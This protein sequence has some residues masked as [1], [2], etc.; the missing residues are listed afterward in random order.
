MFA[1]SIR[2][3]MQLWQAFLLVCILSGFG[4]TAFQL[5]RTNWLRQVD[6]ELERRVAVLSEDVRGPGPLRPP[7]G[8]SPFGPEPGFDRRHPFESGFDA[9]PPLEPGP[10]FGP[11][12]RPRPEPRGPWIPPDEWPEPKDVQ[13]S[14]KALSLFGSVEPGDY[15]Y[16]IWS[17]SGVLLKR[18]TNA[19]PEL[20]LPERSEGDTRILARM[21]EWHREAW[22]FTE[23]GDCVL[24]GRSIRADLEGM[25]RLAGLLAL[26]G[27][28]VLA[29][30][31][32]G[33]WLLAGRALR[34]VDEISAAASRISVGNL[35]ER[36]NMAETDSELGRLAA[37]LNSTFA[38]L[39]AA[40]AAQQQ[41]VADASHELRTPVAVM[42]AEAQST[43]A[44][45][46]AA[47][48]YRE[49][50]ETC[51][52]TAQQMRHLTEQLLQL[53]RFDAGQELLQ[54]EPFDLAE[55]VQT[56]VDR[57]RPLASE[58]GIAIQCDLERSRARGDTERILQVAVNLLSNAIRFN[59]E[60]GAIRV[61]CSV[62]NGA[63]VFSVADTGIGIA[64]ADLGHIFE[65]FYRADEARAGAGGGTGLGLAISQAIV[66][67]HGGSI[68]VTSR[69]GEGTEFVVRLPAGAP[70]APQSGAPDQA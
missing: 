1:K 33:G 40:F 56:A 51:L 46:R 68:A 36:I 18:S 32:G 69:A 59:R 26:A 4:V 41:F 2:W 42:I 20:A 47:G 70:A 3:R 16:S 58:R 8:R 44:R 38:R 10:G 53:A 21:R 54:R 24:A 22:H 5:Q 34:P 28:G 39:E 14:E 43:L 63:A 49:T 30:G 45:P 6:E 50:I 35:S 12:R 67:A 60:G 64:E 27:A 17:R 61:R 25:R 31:L 7:Q 23:M 19:P 37:V 57:V 9:G 11:G 13:L 62:E 66:A 48:E 52:E 65:R 29:L 15:F 55:A